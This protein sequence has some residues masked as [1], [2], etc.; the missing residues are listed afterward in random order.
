[1]EPFDPLRRDSIKRPAPAAP[2]APASPVASPSVSRRPRLLAARVRSVC[3][4]LKD[5]MVFF[6]QFA[7]AVR[8]GVTVAAALNH[9]SQEASHPHLR[10]VA[11]AAQRHVEAGGSLAAFMRER[12]DCFS[13]VEASLIAVGERSGSLDIVLDRMATELEE[14]NT[15]GRRLAVATFLNKYIVLPMLLLVPNVPNIIKYG[16]EALAKAE[17][18]GLRLSEREQQMLILREGFRGYGHDL[19]AQLIPL[20]II[21]GVLYLAF[22]LLTRT[23]VGW[24]AW[25]KLQLL[26]PLFG[27]L[28]RDRAISR[29]LS[30]LGLMTRAGVSP[31]TALET[32]AGISG[33]A[34]LDEKFQAAASLAREQDISIAQALAHTGLLSG[35]TLSLIRTGEQSGETDAMLSR[36]A[37]YYE[38]DLRNRL[39]LL[40]KIVGFWGTMLCVFITLFILRAAYLLLYQNVYEGADK[41]MGV[42]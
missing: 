11:R 27:A 5:R 22:H 18:A 14:E 28:R 12:P 1:M 32:C 23:N 25:E 33:N 10:D 9:L 26:V 2:P 13:R 24:R 17:K 20:A 39:A 19:V 42:D 16:L 7:T 21:V 30:A 15:L 40:P 36:T 6:R 34:A 29:Y 35:S 41:F 3:V 8:A 31:A 38:S 4:K 37:A